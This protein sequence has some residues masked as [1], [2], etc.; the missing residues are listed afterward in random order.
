MGLLVRQL[1]KGPAHLVTDEWISLVRGEMDARGLSP[2]DLSRLSGVSQ[3]SLSRLLNGKLRTARVATRIA[4]ILDLPLPTSPVE[5]DA[6]KAWLELGRNILENDP[7]RFADLL[8]RY[9][10]N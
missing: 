9:S 4:D 8:A 1:P 2:A 6:L 7:K 10:K 3:A 5:S